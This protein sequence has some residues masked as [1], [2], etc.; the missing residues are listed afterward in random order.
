M[1]VALLGFG[2][3]GSGCM[4]S[5]KNTSA[6]VTHVL[7]KREIPEISDILTKD[8][9]DILNDTSVD[10]V[11]EL[12]GGEHPAYDYVKAAILAGKSVVT[13]NKQMLSHHFLEL[14]KL[15]EEKGVFIEYSATSGGGIP[16]L[17]A[18]KRVC[19]TDKILEI[20]GVMNGTTNY[21][22]DA[23]QTK[24]QSYEDALKKA[25]ELGF[26]EADP[27]ADVM[28]YDVQAKLSISCN[29]AFGGEL[30]P[31]SIPTTGITGIT[32]VDVENAQKE[33]K[34]IRLVACA[35]MIDGKIETSIAPKLVG[36]EDPLYN[37]SGS[38]N[39]FYLIGEKTGRLCFRGA[40]AG[41]GPTGRNVADDILEIGRK[42]C[43]K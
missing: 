3:V 6:E 39:L 9:N 43:L 8:I 25:Q 21:I 42:L 33:D 34:A 4:E 29:I 15:A 17:Y 13:A 28:G 7:D 2:T 35:K 11:A 5:L 14:T 1:K 41:K 16:W 23:M 26:A 38:E 37:L 18:L 20:G 31:E 19:R 12:M 30:K 24:G 32:T 10:V 36:K 27:T 40:G 22:L